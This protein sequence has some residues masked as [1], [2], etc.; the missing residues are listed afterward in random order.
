MQQDGAEGGRKDIQEGSRSR[1]GGMVWR[2]RE[3]GKKAKERRR[4]RNRMEVKERGR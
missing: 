3:G 2:W 4:K 1:G